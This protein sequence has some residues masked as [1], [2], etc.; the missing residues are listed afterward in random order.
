M[1]RNNRVKNG[2]VYQT[3]RASLGAT[4]DANAFFTPS[5]SRR[6]SEANAFYTPR[7]SYTNR[8]NNNNN[9]NKNNNNN[10]LNYRNARGAGRTS[11]GCTTCDV[12]SMCLPIIGKVELNCG[13]SVVHAGKMTGIANAVFPK[14]FWS[15]LGV[16]FRSDCG[17]LRCC[18]CKRCLGL[19]LKVARQMVLE[20]AESGAYLRLL[21]L[22]DPSS[23]DIAFFSRLMNGNRMNR[24]RNEVP[25]MKNIDFLQTAVNRGKQIGAL[26]QGPY[27]RYVA[28]GR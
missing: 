22:L 24:M 6:T 26:L 8:N 14:H 17:W 9:N 19:V 21:S 3:P 16:K 10:N 18:I 12:E 7:T 4:N 1:Q 5:T 28:G 20:K 13:R 25:F 11:E 15:Q 2:N 23:P 27:R